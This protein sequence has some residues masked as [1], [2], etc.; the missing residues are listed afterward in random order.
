MRKSSENKMLSNSA[1]RKEWREVEKSR[2][3]DNRASLATSPDE[4]IAHDASR[5]LRFRNDHYR[6]KV[7]CTWI[8]LI[9]LVECLYLYSLITTFDWAWV[10]TT[11]IITVFLCFQVWITNA[12]M[13]SAKDPRYDWAEEYAAEVL[14]WRQQRTEERKHHQPMKD[15]KKQ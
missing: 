8:V 7:N 12:A 4:A 1:R 6:A 5:I 13:K 9:G 3:I 2:I 14:A 10:V 11:G 15:Y